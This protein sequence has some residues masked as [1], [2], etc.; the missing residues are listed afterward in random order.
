MDGVLG[1]GGLGMECL[2]TCWTDVE[3]HIGLFL[4]RVCRVQA[5]GFRLDK[6]Y[7][8]LRVVTIMEKR[9]EKN[10]EIEVETWVVQGAT[11]LNST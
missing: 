7:I 2:K 3:K 5:L 9:V 6:G 4:T 10:M 1:F 11:E 8:W